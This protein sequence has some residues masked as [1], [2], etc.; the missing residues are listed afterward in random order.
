MKHRRRDSRIEATTKGEI[1]GCEYHK[2]LM[3]QVHGAYS[4]MRLPGGSFLGEMRGRRDAGGAIF[5]ESV[6]SAHRRLHSHSHEHAYF[7][8]VIAGSYTERADGHQRECT[9]A[10]VLFH[11][12]G[13]THQ[14]SFGSAGGR[15]FGIELTSR[16]IARLPPGVSCSD[17]K[18]WRGGPA[19][20]SIRK[21]DAV[22]DLALESAVMELVVACAR[23]QATRATPLWLGRVHDLL[24][25]SY[26]QPLSTAG[27]AREMGV[28]ASQIASRFRRHYGCSVGEFVRRLRVDWVVEQLTTS[29]TPLA[30]IAARGGFY[31]QSHLSRLIRVRTGLTPLQ[32]RRLSAR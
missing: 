31:D 22:T 18:M 3:A 29:S 24:R 28:S 26:L 5:T 7:S 15:V 12:A 30:E 2:I 25:A 16:L 32:I 9:S 11:P 19:T 17:P 8:L 1:F 10:S 6:Y 13:E 14:N 23:K 21:A 4:P 20:V 27:I